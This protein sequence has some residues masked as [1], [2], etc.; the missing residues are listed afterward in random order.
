MVSLSDEPI[1]VDRLS[2]GVLAV[3][4]ALNGGFPIGKLVE[5]FGSAGGGKSSIALRA[6]AE[7]Q[8]RGKCVFVDAENALDPFKAENSGINMN[9]L[10]VSQLSSLEKV[11][12]VI[13]LC[14]AADDVSLVVVDS[15]A[16]LTPE[17]EIQGEFGDAHVGLVGR[18]MSQGLR[19]INQTMVETKSR[20]VV[21]FINQVRDNI[22]VMGFGPKTTTPG[23]KALRFWCSTRLEVT[24]TGALK[25][26][27][28]VIGQSVRVKVAKSRFSQPFRQAT[29]EINYETGI[30]NEATLLDNA[31]NAGFIK[32]SKSWFKDPKSDKSYANGRPKMVEYLRENKEFADNLR[33]MLQP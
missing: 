2:S 27:D 19:K 28:A 23:G 21:I 31:L 11:L 30:S 22:G 9:D 14:V 17:A 16:A 32:Q 3:D 13:E 33:E 4:E 10:L 18:L 20:A 24:R 25:Q 29:F 12:E 26:G 5:M 7:A 6:V 8:K 1:E 15:V